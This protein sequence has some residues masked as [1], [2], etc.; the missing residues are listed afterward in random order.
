MREDWAEKLRR[1]L[2]G[3]R[4]S[5]PPG[6]WEGIS[7][8]MGFETKPVRKPAAIRR[9]W[10]AAAVVLA[11]GGFFVF[12][13]GND[14]EQLSQQANVV[15]QP[16]APHQSAPHQ[17]A[18]HQLASQPSNEQPKKANP[19]SQ[20]PQAEALLLA[21]SDL[22][23]EDQP[24]VAEHQTEESS[25]DAP[26]EVQQTPDESD[27][28]QLAESTNDIL[29]PQYE[30]VPM[31]TT[32]SSSGKWSVGLNASRGLLAVNNADVRCDFIMADA[33]YFG[34]SPEMTQP[35]VNHNED[36]SENHHLPI[37]FGL[38]V[39]YQLN[40]RLALLGGISYTRLYSEFSLLQYKL[41]YSYKL[42]YLGIPFGV[43]WQL[44]STRNFRFY[45]S[46]GAMLEKCVSVDTEGGINVRE[47]PWQ[48]S[49]D[50][51]IGAEYGFTRHLGFY[52]EPSLG[53]YFDDGTSLEHYYKEHPLAPSIEF[54]LRLHLNE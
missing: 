39:Q 25:F 19:V 52:L 54:G 9:W 36:Y 37:R 24:S 6:L 13:K 42:H 10:W 1:K 17:S 20:K 33:A 49:V 14:S 31:H 48:W 47:K 8:E 27:T 7:K 46:G 44:W 29:V 45:V 35:S 23:K 30:P 53:Y 41:N 22:V 51:A 50:A 28:K 15:S 18:S 3:H 40:S 34:Y 5:P 2:E 12:Q 11:L 26:A 38:S 21:T 16:L 32:H 43:V 4:K